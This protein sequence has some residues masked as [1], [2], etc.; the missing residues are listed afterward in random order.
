MLFKKKDLL[1]VSYFA[2]KIY[3][4]E[5]ATSVLCYLE[6]LIFLESNIVWF[7]NSMGVQSTD[8]SVELYNIME[9]EYT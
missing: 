3:E 1:E 5:T 6:D 2:G 9:L 7:W 4:K 8:S